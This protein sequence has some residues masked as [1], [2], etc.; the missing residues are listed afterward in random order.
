MEIITNLTA[1]QIRFIGGAIVLIALLKIETL[2]R[3]S[4]K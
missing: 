4:N 2:K 1:E 3:K